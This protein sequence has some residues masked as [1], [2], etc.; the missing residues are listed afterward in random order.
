MR[1]RAPSADLDPGAAARVLTTAVLRASVD[2]D[3][4]RSDLGAMLGVSEA[5]MSRLH[6]GK[7]LV[8]PASKEG[9]LAVMFLRRSRSLDALVGGDSTRARAWI[10]ADNHHLRGVPS[11]LVRTVQGLVQVTEY[12]DAMRGTL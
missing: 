12:V 11:Q 8:D 3:L 7:R 2:L 5:S 10:H 6:A 4:D 9:E 1:S